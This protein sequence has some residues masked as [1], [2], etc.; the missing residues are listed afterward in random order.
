MEVNQFVN[1]HKQID[2]KIS[3]LFNIKQLNR[4]QA[5]NLVRV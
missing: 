4:D 2:K 3:A 5:I 1:G